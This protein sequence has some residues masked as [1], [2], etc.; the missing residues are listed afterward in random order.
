M[1]VTLS[2]C[3]RK[4]ITI[5][6]PDRIPKPIPDV[7]PEGYRGLLE[8]D[9]NICTGCGLCQRTCPIQCIRLTVERDEETKKRYLTRFD[10]DLSKCMDCGLCSEQCPT[11]AIRH[12]REFEGSTLNV[13]NLVFRFIE[14]GKKVEVYKAVKGEPPQGAPVNEPIRKVRKAWN[15]P[16]PFPPDTVRGK[17]MW[18]NADEQHRGTVK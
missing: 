17:V 3:V 18:K 10:I 4:P 14:P 16:A 2:H 9:I 13:V 6:Y 7:L 8:V 1:S 5:Q 15:D 12:S 11:G